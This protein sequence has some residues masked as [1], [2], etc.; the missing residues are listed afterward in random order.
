[1]VGDKKKVRR[2]INVNIFDSFSSRPNV[3][4]DKNKTLNDSTITLMRIFGIQRIKKDNLFDN[5][6]LKTHYNSK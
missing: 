3:K 6:T 1:M 5:T 4:F 2:N